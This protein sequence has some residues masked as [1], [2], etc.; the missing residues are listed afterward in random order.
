MVRR[1]GHMHTM[2]DSDEEDFASLSLMLVATQVDAP[3]SSQSDTSQLGENAE[4]QQGATVEDQSGHFCSR[5]LSTT[6]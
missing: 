4:Q 2:I 5:T 3:L 1:L 6:A